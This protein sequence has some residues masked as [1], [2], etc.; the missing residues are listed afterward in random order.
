MLRQNATRQVEGDDEAGF[1]FFYHV[2][3]MD[4]AFEKF[5]R[6]SNIKKAS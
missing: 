6:L 4:D 5:D 3:D 1:P 2:V